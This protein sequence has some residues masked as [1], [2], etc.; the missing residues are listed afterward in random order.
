MREPT[1]GQLHSSILGSIGAGILLFVVGSILKG[2]FQLGA[3]WCSTFGGP[4]TDC[5]GAEVLFYLGQI[6]QAFGVLSV[7]LGMLLAIIRV[8]ENGQADGSQQRT[9]LHAP[10]PASN[11]PEKLDPTDASTLAGTDSMIDMVNS[12]KQVEGGRPQ[13]KT[14]A[15]AKTSIKSNDSE[16]RGVEYQALMAACGL[17]PAGQVQAARTS[18]QSIAGSRPTP[19]SWTLATS[20]DGRAEALILYP[21]E[22]LVVKFNRDTPFIRHFFSDRRCHVAVHSQGNGSVERIG[23]GP[24]QSGSELQFEWLE[25]PR[26]SGAVAQLLEMLS[27]ESWVD[28][29]TRDSGP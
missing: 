2:H 12:Y 21:E 9:T 23:I 5:T 18:I 10:R 26:P 6:L 8:L 3:V 27:V 14:L 16:F 22:L 7:V 24:G 13:G 15:K 17:L 29:E 4:L 19:R 28:V 25:V 11:Q 20:G 1:K